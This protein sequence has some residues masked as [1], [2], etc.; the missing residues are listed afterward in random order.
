[1]SLLTPGAHPVLK[2]IFIVFEDDR[3]K[4]CTHI[5]EAFRCIIGFFTKIFS[6]HFSTS[7]Y[8][9]LNKTIII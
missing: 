1:M 5:Q 8:A 4:R 7:T 6:P 9:A 2:A 3:Q